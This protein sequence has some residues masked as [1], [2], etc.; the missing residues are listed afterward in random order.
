MPISVCM[1]LF[2]FDFSDEQTSTDFIRLLRL[3]RC[4]FLHSAL[5][6]FVLCLNS[7]T[8]LLEFLTIAFTCW[9]EIKCLQ[10]FDFIEFS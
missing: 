9:S 2:K 7:V 8:E 4:L 3:V 5:L 10:F 6:Y 1:I